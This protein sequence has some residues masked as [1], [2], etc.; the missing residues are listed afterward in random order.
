MKK[1]LININ[2]KPSGVNPTDIVGI[3]KVGFNVG[4][5][6]GAKVA[7]NVAAYPLSVGKRF[8]HTQKFHQAISNLY[9]AHH[10]R[11]TTPVPFEE[12]PIGAFSNLRDKKA[13]RAFFKKFYKKGGI[14]RFSIIN[15]PNIFYI[16]ST[17]KFYTRFLKHTAPEAYIYNYD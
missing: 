6:V 5:N 1:Y 4:F 11:K 16:G 14:Y 10:G 7:F 17:G 12:K 3:F 13:I 15:K 2:N 8:H 9:R